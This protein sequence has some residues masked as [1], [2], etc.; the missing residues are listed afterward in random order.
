MRVTRAT[1]VLWQT[2]SSLLTSIIDGLLSNTVISKF[3]VIKSTSHKT[4]NVCIT[5]Y[6]GAFV[7]PLLQG[8]S[9]NYYIF[10][11]RVCSLSY[12]TCNA[13]APFYIV[14]CGL[15]DSTNF[16]PS[17]SHKRH[18][19]LKKKILNKKGFYNFDVWLTVHRSSMWIKRPT[20]CHF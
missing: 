20:R 15:S 16:F 14:I 11:M 2:D 5:W 4:R 19:F 18:D 7:Q 12:P 17:S 10:W 13:H 3:S 6:W 8:K 1:S 9:H